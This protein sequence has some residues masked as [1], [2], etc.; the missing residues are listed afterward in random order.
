MTRSSRLLLFCLALITPA[1]AQSGTPTP[2]TAPP[3][4]QLQGE[5]SDPTRP[6]V[7]SLREEY[8][9]LRGSDAWANAFIVRRDK[10][11][12]EDRKEWWTGKRGFITRFDMPLVVTH[13]P[14]ETQGGLGDLYLQALYFPHLTRKFAF[15]GGTGML[16][17]TAT[18]EL[19][20]TGKVTIA[21]ALA[22][23]WFI[24]R[25]G[26]FFIKLQ[27]FV[28]VAGDDSRPDLH[29][30]T[31][32]PLLTWSFQKKWW[33]QLDGETKT[34]FQTG[35]NSGYRVGVLLGRVLKNRFGAWVKVE[36][37]FGKYREGD[38]SI[39]TSLFRVK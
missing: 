22:P 25:R 32:N 26:M 6:V 17:P 28:S 33:T 5:D 36:V 34:N 4:P 39:K 21:P 13:N 29:Y 8:Y 37:P 16:L 10:A 7:W 18:D 2:T 24:P 9:N 11:F 1:S 35:G 23:V 27:D 14:V 38:V 12:F 15:A 30:F 31:T 19:L 3:P 20:G